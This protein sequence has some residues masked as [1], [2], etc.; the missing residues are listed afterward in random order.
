M[1]LNTL[2]ISERTLRSWL[3]DGEALPTVVE[4]G[5]SGKQISAAVKNVEEFL[6]SLPKVELHYCR[7]ASSKFYLEP[8]WYSF[9]NIHRH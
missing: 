9:R 6:N 1:F 3:L 5:T 4:N 7:S 8:T 2:C